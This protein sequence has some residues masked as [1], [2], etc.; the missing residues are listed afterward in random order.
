MAG[1]ILGAIAL[2]L[3]WVLIARVRTYGRLLADAHFLAIGRGAPALKQA[4]LLR[5][6]AT[7][8]NAVGDPSD[9]RILKSAAGLV[10]VYTVSKREA[11]FVHHCSASVP[12]DQ[13]AHGALDFLL[14][15]VLLVLGLPSQKANVAIGA[16]N[17]HHAELLLSADEHA[18]LL[19]GPP[20]DTSDASLF[21]LRATAAQARTRG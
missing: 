3:L 20:L 6:M 19:A 14:S 4:A 21:A 7:H 17:V 5:I 2:L 8:E 16:G 12:G 15:Y 13:V 18:A 9:P 1:W 11:E 10:I